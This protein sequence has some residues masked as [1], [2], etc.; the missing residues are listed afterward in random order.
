MEDIKSIIAENIVRLRRN[1]GLTQIEL[2]EKLNYSDKAV[3][4]WERGESVPDISVLKAIADL[5]GVTVDY[6]ITADH[7]D[8]IVTDDPEQIKQMEDKQRRRKRKRVM[9][10]GMSVLLVWLVAACVF[11]PID[12]ALKNTFAHWITFAYAVPVSMLVWLIFNAMWFNRR[13]NFLIISLMVWTLLTAIHLTIL[14]FGYNIWQFY[15]LGIPGQLI[16]ILW[17]IIGKKS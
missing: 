16:I 17:S 10:A 9:I 8:E 7:K 12:I 6:L 2:A 15:L 11:V 5:F 4:K 3:S 1:S 13:R 14:I